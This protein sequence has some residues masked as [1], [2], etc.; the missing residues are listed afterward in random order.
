MIETGYENDMPVKIQP[1]AH[2]Q[3]AFDFVSD[4]FG[5]FSDNEK[6]NGAALFM[7]MGTGK[8]LVAIGIAGSLFLRGKVK[9]VLVVAPLSVLGVWEIEFEKSANFSYSL[10]LLSG[11]TKNKVK[12]LRDF[13]G[14]GLKVVLVNYD[15]VWRIENELSF[16][17]PDIIIADESHRIKNPRC[18]RSSA[19]YEIGEIAKYRLILSGTPF[20]NSP[21]DIFGQYRFLDPEV[22][23]TDLD[24]FCGTYCCN[25]TPYKSYPVWKVRSDRMDLLLRKYREIAFYAKKKDCLTLPSVLE[26]VYNVKLEKGAMRKYRDIVD[27]AKYCLQNNTFESGKYIVSVFTRLSQLTGGFIKDKTGVSYNVSKAKLQVLLSIIDFAIAEGNKVVVML[28]YVNELKLI[29][30]SLAEKK[31]GFTDLYGKTKNREDSIKFFQTDKNCHVFIGQIQTAGNGISLTAASIMIFYSFD[32]SLDNFE[33]A[34]ARI[35]RAGQTKKCHYIYLTCSGTI[36]CMVLNKLREKQNI[37]KLL[38]NSCAE[39]GGAH[40]LDEVEKNLDT[41]A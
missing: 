10:L 35:H 19:L 13:T 26:Q 9:T 18:K 31:I 16:F 37:A 23:G 12:Q 40:L 24:D 11:S 14:E 33:Q 22:F 30:A 38:T 36:D 8:T 1:Y 5:I 20:S 2:Q 32:Y 4:L 34:K 21:C 17:Y 28:R 39:S 15:S 6:R 3:K 25:V 41:D 7:E 27:K 29:E